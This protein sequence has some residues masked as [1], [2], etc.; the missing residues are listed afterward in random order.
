MRLEL[1][2]RP[3]VL[4]VIP[5]PGATSEARLAAV[6]V[7][8]FE[9]RIAGRPVHV[10]VDRGA[11][12]AGSEAWAKSIGGTTSPD[13][14]F[15][16]EYSSA[17]DTGP[18]TPG[19]ATIDVT[20]SLA[21][22]QVL[23]EKQYLTVV[24][25]PASITIAASP[26]AVRCGEAVTITTTV[27]DAIGQ[28]VGDGHK[29]Q[30]WTNVGGRL[31][32][33]IEDTWNGVATT[34]LLTSRLHDGPYVIIGGVAD[35][36]GARPLIRAQVTVRAVRGEANSLFSSGPS[37]DPK[38]PPPTQVG[39]DFDSTI[40]TVFTDI[41]DSSGHVQA[42]GDS[43]WRTL[44]M[45]HN[46]LLRTAIGQFRGTEQKKLGDG[47]MVT[48]ASAHAAIESAIEMQRQMQNF[49]STRGGEPLLIKVGIDTGEP[50]AVEG[51][52]VGLS[53]H[54]SSRIQ[55]NAKPQEILVS[56]VVKTLVANRKFKFGSSR[57]IQP[58]GFDPFTVWPVD[59]S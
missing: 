9:R 5:P 3:S 38:P 21:S 58:K 20:V 50:A 40:T 41:V 42:L 53:P 11:L 37:Q 27:K 32:R 31:A 49:N 2:A 7:D 10:S 33:P 26:A 28:S 4:H 54:I 12:R 30:F 59:W 51:D 29:V 55:A 13:G 56:D 6:A 52:P 44:L 22:G 17:V 48:F 25:P 36:V 24:G 15:N 18:P 39:A 45:Q 43:D 23:S 57:Q 8:D 34:F 47:F 16:F 19:L 14:L 1:Y 46:E 35:M